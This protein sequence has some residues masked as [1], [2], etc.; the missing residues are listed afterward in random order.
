VDFTLGAGEESLLSS[1]GR[2]VAMFVHER[3]DPGAPAVLFLHGAGASGLMWRAH[4][5]RLQGQFH[6]LAPDLP[7]FG[8]SESVAF[9]SRAVTAEL[10]AELVGSRAQGGRA[11]VVALSWGGGVAHEL[12]GR[13]PWVVDR[14]VIDGAGVLTS[15]SGPAILAGIST[16][17]PMLHTRA[18]SGLFARMIGMDHQGRADLLA[19]SPSA[20][21]RAFIEGFRSGVSRV[22]CAAPCPTLLVAGEAETAVRPANAALASVMPQTQARYVAG[23][24]HGWLA[25]R[26]DLHVAMVEAWLAGAPLPDALLPEVASP[27]VVARLRRELG[28][29]STP[30]AGVLQGSP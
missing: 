20:F 8:R 14:A 22:E 4:L 1:M 24:G 28:E 7:G 25:R 3:G 17:A 26:P 12:L 19:A 11:H 15:R 6:C 18:V 21:R 13:R 30:L 10:V 2:D 16:V 27:A 9:V 29:D 23:V 5:D